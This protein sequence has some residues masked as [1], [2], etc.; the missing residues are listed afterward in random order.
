M[1]SNQLFDEKSPYLQQHADNPVHWY[2]WGEEAFEAAKDRDKPIFLSIGYATCHWCHVMAHESFEDEEVANLMN[3]AFINI[4]VDREERPDI[5]NTYMT[6][7]QMMTGSGGWPLTIFMTPEKQ[8]FYAGTYIPKRGRQGRPGMVDLI[9]WIRDLWKNERDKVYRSA[10]EIKDAF[11]KSNV[12][13]PGKGP[14]QETLNK[15]FHQFKQQFDRQHGGFGQSPKFPSPHNLMFLLRYWKQSGDQ[16]ALVMVEQTL[17]AMRRGGVYDHIGYGFHRYATDAQWLLP[18]FEKMLYDQALLMMAYTEGWQATGN[19]LFKQ[20]ADEI[21]TYISRD[22]LD[23]NG[24]FYSAEDADSEGEEGKFYVWSTQEIRDL[25]PTADAE[26][27]I[28]VY[29]LEDQGNFKEEASG[30]KTGKNIPHLQKS[31]EDLAAER[32]M[33]VEEL[34]KKL[35]SIRKKLFQE[36]EKRVRPFLDDKILTDWNGLAIA[37]LAKAGTIFQEQE[38]IERAE[39]AFGFISANLQKEDG[40]LLHRYREGEAAIDGNADD[41]AFLTWGLLELYEATFDT[42]YLQEALR[43]NDIFIEHFW[44]RENGGF[45]FTSHQSEELLGRKKEV[46]DGAI[47]SGNSVAMQNLVRLGRIT[48]NTGWEEK[49]EQIGQLFSE[50]LEKAPTGFGQMLQ[51]VGFGLG[52]SYEIVIA[53]RKDTPATRQLRDEIFS[54]FIPCKV[55]ILNEPGDETIRELAPYTRDQPMIEGKSA[56]YVCRNYSCER[57]VTEPEKLAQQLS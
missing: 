50:Q 10:R 21:A 46:Y 49:A 34:N 15:A 43:L 3:E 57:P 39:R 36:R 27:F 26:L 13:T 52:P 55:V 8:P 29:N 28:E 41:Y 1:S 42:E 30:Q 25:L 54:H 38:Y 53:G 18:H 9:P 20:T 4:K 16:Q 40:T 48:G 44:D 35:N 37:A 7:C 22:L 17:E 31:I 6:V 11:Q 32:D 56:V 33:T 47:P 12:Q 2:P 23:E 45:Y 5:D 51:G 19:G 14:S 24:A